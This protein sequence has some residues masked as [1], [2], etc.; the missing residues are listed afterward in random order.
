[1]QD[2]ELVAA[3]MRAARYFR[4]NKDNTAHKLDGKN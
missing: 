1:M 2:P 4:I 3:A